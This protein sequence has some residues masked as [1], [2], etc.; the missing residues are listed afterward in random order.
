MSFQTH[1]ALKPRT[2]QTYITHTH[3]WL[4]FHQC[5]FCSNM[6]A[7]GSK[8]QTFCLSSIFVLIH[9]HI[10]IKCS[11]MY[12]KACHLISD[13]LWILLPTRQPCNT[14]G[15]GQKKKKRKAI[16]FAQ[17]RISNTNKYAYSISMSALFEHFPRGL[18]LHYYIR[19]KTHSQKLQYTLMHT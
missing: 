19:A 15:L 2:L 17:W 11:D 5:L 12:I 16:Q 8:T 7:R 14:L 4:C 13:K 10:E 3:S 1:M 9:L 18:E 6:L